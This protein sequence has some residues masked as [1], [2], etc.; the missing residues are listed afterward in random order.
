MVILDHLWYFAAKR[1][2][3]MA[4]FTNSQPIVNAVVELEY[5][6]LKVDFIVTFA[7]A[8]S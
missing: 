4:V 2:Y 5:Q 1:D 6:V 7:G 3:S 8:I